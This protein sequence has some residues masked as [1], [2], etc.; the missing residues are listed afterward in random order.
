MGNI[1]NREGH[2]CVDAGSIWETFSQ[3]YCVLK[4]VLKKRN[5][6]LKEKNSASELSCKLSN[7]ALLVVSNWKLYHYTKNVKPGGAAAATPACSDSLT[8]HN[9]EPYSRVIFTVVLG[10]ILTLNKHNM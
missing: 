3:F 1:D 5:L 8:Q 2:V 4:T 9:R 6:S 10:D 7:A